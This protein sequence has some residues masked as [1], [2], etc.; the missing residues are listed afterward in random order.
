MSYRFVD[1]FRAGAYAEIWFWEFAKQG[2]VYILLSYDTKCL[3]PDVETI[4][5]L[6]AV[7]FLFPRSQIK[8]VPSQNAI[9]K[10]RFIFRDRRQ[11][12]SLFLRC[13]FYVCVY[14]WYTIYLCWLPIL[15]QSLRVLKCL[16]VESWV[17]KHFNILHES[18]Q[19]SGSKR[20]TCLQRDITFYLLTLSIAQMTSNCS[21]DQSSASHR[22]GLGSITG[23]SM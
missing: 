21:G 5:L 19:Q 8:Y 6:P 16:E 23:P 13:V 12:F 18:A 9:E 7:N 17:M 20:D 1:S 22:Q 15:I 11:Q 4:L 3:I 10:T 14:R 2:S